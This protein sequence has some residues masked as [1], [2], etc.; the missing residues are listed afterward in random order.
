MIEEKLEKRI[1]QNDE[2]REKIMKKSTSFM[3][4]KQM[5]QCGCGYQKK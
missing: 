3:D 5:I 1:S 2:S 4:K